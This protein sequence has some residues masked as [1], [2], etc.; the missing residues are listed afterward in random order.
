MCLPQ[1]IFK[2][3]ESFS[4]IFLLYESFITFLMFF[5]GECFIEAKGLV[6][7]SKSAISRSNSLK[8]TV[9]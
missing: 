1:F 6:K 8:F 3:F 2:E 7:F 9:K 5:F 4:H